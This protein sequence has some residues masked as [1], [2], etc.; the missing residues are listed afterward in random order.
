MKS[1]MVRL[2]LSMLAAGF[3]AGCAGLMGGSQPA[4]FVP[5]NFATGEYTARAD[6]FQVI[7]DA[8]Q[9]MANDGQANFLTA[10]NF[11]AAVNQ[12][13]PAD[14][15]ADMGL[16]SYGHSEK[17]SA[18]LTDLVYG[19]ANYSR[20]E[21]AKGL[22]KIKYPGGNSPLGAA[23]NAASADLEKASGTS[24]LVIVSDG[25]QNNMDDA[26]AAAKAIKAKMADRICIYTV[27]VGNDESGRKVLEKVAQAGSCGTADSAASLTDQKALAAYVERV[28][29][30]RKPAPAPAP[31]PAPTPAPAPVAAPAPV[32]APA[33]CQGVITANL[34]FDF[35]KA[36]IKDDMIP[37]LEEAKRIMN[38]CRTINYQVAGHTC[39][40]GT[41]A[42]NQGLS[43]R[44]A[45]AV[46][47]WL[48]D[49][50]VAADRLETF[51]Y[52]EGSP[53]YDNSTTDGRKLN[54]R[55]EFRAK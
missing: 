37:V 55:V 36:T 2:G 44:R 35:D 10:K 30:D 45:A 52:G 1:G 12:S 34:V 20:E 21:M 19:M 42:Y 33:P 50:G 32:P 3:L 24:V 14:F 8:S 43:E 49:N 31:A 11:V 47:K 39:S 9:T 41:D 6:N 16:R 13:L 22:D 38:E 5:T 53:K 23:I 15:G 18:K 28:F 27:W 4:T 40:I 48:V 51:G 7:V 46:T 17:Q 54:R 29:F 25:T 26:V